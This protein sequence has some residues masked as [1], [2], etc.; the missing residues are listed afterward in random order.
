MY[1]LGILAGLLLLFSFISGSNFNTAIA[2]KRA[3]HT[4]YVSGQLRAY[5]SYVAA[6]ARANPG[7]NGGVSDATVGVPSWLSKPPGMSGY[8]TGGRAFVYIKPPTIAEANEIARSCG[9]SLM[10]GVTRSSSLYIPGESSPASVTLPSSIPVSGALV[11][12]L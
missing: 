9:G 6:Y 1:P 5:G 8:V 3:A 7:A 11:L 4:S 10:C 2:D 12:V